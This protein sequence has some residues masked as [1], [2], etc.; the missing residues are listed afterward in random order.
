MKTVL[1][2]PFDRW[3]ET[4]LLSIGLGAALAG[5]FLGICFDAR[6]DGALDLHFA[7]DT[8]VKTMAF[9][10]LIDFGTLFLFLYA[11]A[12]IVNRKTRMV[13]ILSAV[14]ISRI[15]MYLLTVFNAGNVLAAE[16]DRVAKQAMAHEPVTMS[17]FGMVLM[18]GFVIL[19]LLFVVW[20]VTLLWNGYRTASNAKGGKPIVLF[21][22]GLLLA[23]IASKW[24]IA[25]VTP[26]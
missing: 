12:K 10:L 6:F 24:L 22:V 14:L 11:A 9:D 21:I 8:S 16:G 23:E 17:P 2:K 7:G 18:I 3:S 4:V 15:P 1:F 20:S 5:A 25:Y 19:T 26:Y 13:D